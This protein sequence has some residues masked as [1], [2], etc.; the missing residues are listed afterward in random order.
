[1]IGRSSTPSGCAGRAVEENVRC[2]T[3][4][5][6]QVV[7]R[8]SGR[9]VRAGAGDFLNGERESSESAKRKGLA[10]ELGCLQPG[11]RVRVGW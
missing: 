6:P 11:E 3:H 7:E 10:G 9:N 2:A 8:S 1:V 4:T 5:L